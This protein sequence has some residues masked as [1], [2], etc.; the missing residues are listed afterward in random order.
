MTLTELDLFS[1]EERRL[2]RA[3]IAPCH[4]LKGNYRTENGRSFSEVHRKK[5]SYNDDKF[6]HGKFQ[7]DIKTKTHS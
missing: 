5:A 6:Q 2:S 4:C 3:L 7:L 1:P